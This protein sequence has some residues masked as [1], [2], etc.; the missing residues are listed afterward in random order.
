MRGYNLY[1]KNH[2]INTRV[3]TKQKMERVMSHNHVTCVNPITRER[4]IIPTNDITCIECI[5][6]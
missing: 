2:K 6:V 3:I 4:I 5:M 1:Y